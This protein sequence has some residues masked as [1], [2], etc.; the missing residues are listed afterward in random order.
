MKYVLAILSLVFFASCG[1]HPHEHDSLP[2]L[3]PVAEVKENINAQLEA[4]H[5]AAAEANF[6]TYFNLMTDDGVF[7]GTDA[8]E[9]WQSVEFLNT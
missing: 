2:E 7:I 6:E 1:E 8:T 5:K 9:N 4:W 3:K